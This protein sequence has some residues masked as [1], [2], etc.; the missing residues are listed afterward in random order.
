M[1]G[2]EIC[3]LTGSEWQGIIEKLERKAVPNAPYTNRGAAPIA[4]RA[5]HNPAILF[6]EINIYLN[7]WGQAGRN[8]GFA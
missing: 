6:T 8:T 7:L 1:E 2:S 3:R 4:G 5:A